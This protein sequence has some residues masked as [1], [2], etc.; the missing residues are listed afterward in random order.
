MAARLVGK[1][2]MATLTI[3]DLVGVD[4]TAFTDGAGSVLPWRIC[5]GSPLPTGAQMR[6]EPGDLTVNPAGEPAQALRD[7]RDFVHYVQSTQGHLNG[8][9]GL[10]FVRRNYPS[11]P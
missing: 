10:C 6:F 2:A 8:G 1:P 3:D 7:Y 5:D 11:P 9:E 4:P